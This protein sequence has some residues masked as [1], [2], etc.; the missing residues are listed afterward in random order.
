MP[1]NILNLPEYTVTSVKN[2]EAD[3]HIEAE[4]KAAATH[5]A[6]CKSTE[7]VGFG[8]REQLVKDLPMHGRRVGI[9]ISVRRI[10][11]KSCAKTFSEPL[12]EVDTE[13]FMTKRLLEWIGKAA[14]RR[15][16]TSIAEEVGIVEGTVRSIFRDYINEMQSTV[17]FETPQWMGIDEIHLIKPRGVITNIQNNT[18]VEVLRD[19]NK[20]TVADFL[21]RLNG[22]DNIKYVA[23]DM[24]RPYR[25]AVEVVLPQ[26]T[27]VIDKFHVVRLANDAMES[28]RKSLRSD[29]TTK[30]RRGL[31]HDRFVLLKRNRE[32]ADQERFNLDGWV[33]NYPLLGEAYTLKESFFEIYA[34]R[35]REAAFNAYETWA[36]SIPPE[37][38]EA[39]S[40]L[41]SAVGNWSPYIFSY[42]DHP[43]TNAYTE[44]LNNLIRVMNRLGRGYS[45]EALRAKIL[46]SEGAHKISKPRPKFERRNEVMYDTIG[47]S[48][49]SAFE[50]EK[51]YGS[52]I[53]TLI[54]LIENGEL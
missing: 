53:S 36:K 37:L 25:E 11:C 30:Q 17:K 27:I 24:W 5:C 12:P 19:R 49:A 35:S 34:H 8:K 40:P 50:R 32:L 42:F 21:F 39:F 29:L 13:R 31:M 48:L 1:A 47:Y 23:M 10:K 18:V 41:K 46:F 43:I 14:I 16:F 7:L 52:D 26:A 6:Y 15:T 20:K 51:N 9:Y 4:I 28:I 22:R 3:Y 38:N 54:R 33:Q 45:F 44:S 2:T